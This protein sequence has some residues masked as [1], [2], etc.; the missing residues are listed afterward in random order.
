MITKHLFLTLN[1][2]VNVLVYKIV[3]LIVFLQTILVV[4]NAQNPFLLPDSSKLRP[5]IQK[6]KPPPPPRPLPRWSDFK[7]DSDEEKAFWE[8]LPHQAEG[9]GNRAIWKNHLKLNAHGEKIDSNSTYGYNGYVKTKTRKNRTIYQFVNGYAVRSKSWNHEGQKISE[10]SYMDGKLHG[11]SINWHKD[12]NKIEQTTYIE[13]SISKIVMWNSPEEKAYWDALPE[14]SYSQVSQDILERRDKSGKKIKHSSTE[15]FYGMVK[16]FTKSIRYLHQ[17][18]DGFLLRSK[19]WASH[20]KVLSESNYKEGSLHGLQ[21]VYGYNNG[22]KSSEENYEDGSRHGLSTEWY[23]NGQKSSE[24]NWKEGET[25]GQFTKWYKN[26]QKSWEANYKEG[27]PHGSW[28]EWY[29]NGQKSAEENWKEG[30]REGQFT[31]WY[32]NGQT[33][34]LAIYVEDKLVN[35]VA[36]KPNGEE[37]TETNVKEGDGVIIIWHE[38]GQKSVE[39]N[40]KEGIPH[41]SWTEWYENGQKSSERNYKDGARNGVWTYWQKN[42]DK[43]REDTFS[44]DILVKLLQKTRTSIDTTEW[45]LEE[46]YKVGGRPK[47]FEAILMDGMMH[48]V[49]VWKGWGGEVCSLSK[50][51]DGTGVIVHYKLSGVIDF[52]E[53]FENGV[54][55]EKIFE[56]KIEMKYLVGEIEPK[57]L[58]T[59]LAKYYDYVGSPPDSLSDLTSPPHGIRPFIDHMKHLEDPWGKRFQYKYPGNKNKDCFDLWTTDENGR[60]I[61][62]WDVNK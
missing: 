30:E 32:K 35:A 7:Y 3:T 61:G 13:G 60:V 47:K 26:G 25:E 49:K 15:S 18:E 37:C 36:H 14:W 23:E 6:P 62:N 24:K 56:P 52:R 46:W 44:E 27:F 17:F 41:G 34:I 54:M 33:K 4:L 12:Q 51:N 1:V 8:K 59:A 29:E 57:E 48:D 39:G 22:Q 11:L 38:N 55:I 21:T 9:S 28:T 40:Y 45:F 5:V 19:S 20:G 2:I 16:V 10:K 50:L 43:I 53:I 42:G 31:Q 58:N